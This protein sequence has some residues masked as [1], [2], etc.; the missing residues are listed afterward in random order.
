MTKK[1]TDKKSAAK[2]KAKAKKPDQLKLAGTERTDSIPE[3]ED[4]D[5]EY[6]ETRDAWMELQKEMG[7]AQANLTTVMKKHGV[8]TYLYEAKDGRQYEAYVPEADDPQAKSR[9]V[10]KP[11]TKAP[12]TAG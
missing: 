10:K 12:E 6:R 3:I 4:A 8:D 5:T 1:K 11:K 7:E 2:A 9:V